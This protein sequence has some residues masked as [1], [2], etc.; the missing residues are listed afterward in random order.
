MAA[1]ALNCL[2][3]LILIYWWPNVCP[4][5]H[6]NMGLSLI[7]A[8]GATLSASVAL[9]GPVF[10]RLSGSH[11]L[12]DQCFARFYD[13][14]HLKR[15]PRQRVTRLQLRRD[16]SGPARENNLAR[17]TVA[18]G[19]RTTAGP[20]RFTVYG[21][22]TTRGPIAECGGEGDAGRFRLVLEGRNLR[23]EID[24]LE[25]EDSG[26][27]LAKSDDRTFLLQPAPARE[28]QG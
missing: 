23:V 10:N 5:H 22:C 26:A 7:I 28:C 19:F 14:A 2:R 16:R 12:A 25:L 4:N 3:N 15:H 6:W 18:V 8:A 9:A 21:I 1:I 11:P 13:A 17:F 20:N 27:D 24:R